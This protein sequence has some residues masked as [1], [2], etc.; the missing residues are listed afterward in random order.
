MSLWLCSQHGVTG[1][2]PCCTQ[3]ELANIPPPWNQCDGCARGLRV[4]N[5]IHYDG[6]RPD[7]ACTAYRYSQSDAA[8]ESK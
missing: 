3:A 7:M 1:P 5:S 2:G 6:G 4:E 8:E